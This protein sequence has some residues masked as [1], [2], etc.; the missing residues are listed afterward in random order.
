MRGKLVVTAPQG[1]N[2]SEVW[3]LENAPQLEREVVEL[4]GTLVLRYEDYS[5]GNYGAAKRGGLTMRL[6]NAKDG[7]PLYSIFNA[8][9]LR[10]RT[11][12]SGK[13]GTPLPAGQFHLKKGC[14][15]LKLWM[16]T[17][18]PLPRRPLS[19]LH[20][21]MGKLK[22]ILLTGEM[23]DTKAE[24]VISSSIKPLEITAGEIRNLLA[25]ASLPDNARPI[26]GHLP[27]SSRTNLP[28]KDHRKP[29]VYQ[30][31]RAESNAGEI[32]C[33]N[34]VI[35]DTG[36]DEPLISE[37]VWEEMNR[38]LIEEWIADHELL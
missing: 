18:L 29:N 15:L 10:A 20:D 30:M 16:L 19:A 34:K 4:S 36:P 27:D 12:K 32:C 8:E 21:Y 31:V 6:T 23:H 33:G 38:E 5:T 28:D 26:S 1:Q 9:L 7:T 17:G 25:A 14:D 2:M 22:A 13:A 24:R 3:L 11:T 35:R 37:Q